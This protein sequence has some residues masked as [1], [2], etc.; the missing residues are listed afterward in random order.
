MPVII[1]QC[2]ALRHLDHVLQIIVPTLIH[3]IFLDA[4]VDDKQVACRKAFPHWRQVASDI[5]VLQRNTAAKLAYL[6][7]QSGSMPNGVRNTGVPDLDARRLPVVPF[8]RNI[9]C[10]EGRK[11]ASCISAVDTLTNRLTPLPCSDAIV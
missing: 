8:S 6:G 5:A 7:R 1:R 4:L 3:V 11:S 9:S 2:L 10:N